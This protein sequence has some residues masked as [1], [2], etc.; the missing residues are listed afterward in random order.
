[1]ERHYK[2][3]DRWQNLNYRA[4]KLAKSLC[5]N[6]TIKTTLELIDGIC[7]SPFIDENSGGPERRN[8]LPKVAVN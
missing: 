2:C 4:A 5:N 1:M 8:G 3:L 6:L 7:A